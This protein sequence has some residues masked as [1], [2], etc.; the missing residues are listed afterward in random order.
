[1][2][3]PCSKR[4]PKNVP[5]TGRQDVP[6]TLPMDDHHFSSF[7]PL[8][9]PFEGI[10]RVRIFK[11]HPGLKSSHGCLW[12]GWCFEFFP[13]VAKR[14]INPPSWIWV[15][16][17]SVKYHIFIF[18]VDKISIE[19]RFI[20]VDLHLSLILSIIN[21]CRAQWLTGHQADFPL[22][23]G[24]GS[25]ISQAFG[26]RGF[27][28]SRIPQFPRSRASVPGGC[29]PAHGWRKWACYMPCTMV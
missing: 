16:E 21:P 7:S 13:P 28:L 25:H 6:S 12:Y 11:P 18:M 14:L 26:H 19:H 3:Y 20:M 9:L 29:D 22:G 2:F 8:K 17:I 27:S 10:Q 24:P 4:V 1:M 15:L 5:S 23:P